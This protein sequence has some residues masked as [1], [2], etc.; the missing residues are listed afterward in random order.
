M[1]VREMRPQPN[2]LIAFALTIFCA[3]GVALPMAVA[4]IWICS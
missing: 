1:L 4:I 2:L 3:L